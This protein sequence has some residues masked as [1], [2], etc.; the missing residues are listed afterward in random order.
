MSTIGVRHTISKGGPT[1][2]VI[3][4]DDLPE[5]LPETNVLACPLTETT[6]GLVGETEFDAL[7]TDAIV[8]NVARGVVIDTPA[9]VN[10]LQSNCIHG[11]GLDV[12]DPEPLPSNHDLWRFENVFLTPHVAGHTP[13]YWDRRADIL[14]ENLMRVAETGGYVDLRNQVT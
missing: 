7:P 4:Y 9:L 5:V 6:E 11:A 3:G 2:K 14:V 13:K 1:D 12:T 10:A 8:V